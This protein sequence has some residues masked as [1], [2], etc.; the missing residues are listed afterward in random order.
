[1]GPGS[2][3]LVNEAGREAWILLKGVEVGAS[4]DAETLRTENVVVKI[5]IDEGK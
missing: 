3:C 1:M 4:G 2:A 5:M